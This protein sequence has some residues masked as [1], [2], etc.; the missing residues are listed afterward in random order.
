M[1]MD[2]NSRAKIDKCLT[3]G[4]NSSW[5]GKTFRFNG[6]A[7][8][9]RLRGK[10][11]LFVGDSL[12]RNQ[13]NSMICMLNS[14]I[15]GVKNTSGGLDGQLY[16]FKAIDYSI[17]IDF[18]W[19]PMLVESNG[20][21]PTNHRCDDRIVGIKSIEK[22]AKHWLDDPNQEYEEVD[23]LR[24]Y[25]MGLR[26]WSKWTQT[27]IDPS[28]TKLFFMGVTATHLRWVYD[29]SSRYPL[30]K[31]HECPYLEETFACQTYGR[32]DVKYLEWR[33]QPHSCNFPTFNGKALIERLRGKRILFVGDSLNRNQW[34]SMICMLNSLIPGVKNAGGGL[35][36]LLHTFKAIDYNISIDFYWAPM[37]VE[38]IATHSR[39]KEWGGKNHANC[40]GETEPVMDDRFWERRTDPQMLS[41]L[42]SSLRKLKAKGKRMAVV[43]V[44]LEVYGLEPCNGSKKPEGGSKSDVDSGMNGVERQ[45]DGMHRPLVF[46]SFLDEEPSKKKVNF[47]TLQMEQ[48]NLADVLIHM[49]LILEVHST[50]HP[51]TIAKHRLETLDRCKLKKEKSFYHRYFLE[52]ILFPIV[53]HKPFRNGK[54][55]LLRVNMKEKAMQKKNKYYLQVAI[56]EV[57]VG[58]PAARSTERL[59][60]L[61]DE[62]HVISFSVV[63]GDHRLANYRSVTTLHP[64][65]TGNGTVVVESYVVDIPPGNTKEEPC[66]F[67]DTIVKCN[68]QSLAQI[69]EN[70]L[71]QKISSR[72]VERAAGRPEMT[73]TSR[74][75]PTSPLPTRTLQLLTKCL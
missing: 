48:T 21:S 51:W 17:S 9:E 58:L 36:G 28:K 47:C 68:L 54:A 75:V 5:V 22:H 14:L 13:W 33:W 20:D 27:H 53:A 25:K 15:S 1:N 70:K 42:E 31:E 40:Y 65:P 71:Q 7:L 18:Y 61:D 37:L 3:N 23:S 57:V 59:E 41:V 50:N 39:A 10:R 43:V 16:T 72:S 12:N 6:K 46:A 8:I 11:I 32:K 62:R 30:Y 29:N 4:K 64:N 34:I 49:S 24:A 19:A 56:K 35:D 69:A 38:S 55:S 2:P 45:H 60:I 63:G 52:T 67:V 74:K 26:T 73:C 44:V 66:V